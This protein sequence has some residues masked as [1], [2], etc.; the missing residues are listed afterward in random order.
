MC[1]REKDW[2]L[3]YVYLEPHTK[4]TNRKDEWK[5]KIVLKIKQKKTNWKSKKT[6]D[7]II[8]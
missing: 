2:C 5:E 4:H 1:D 8:F 7:K 3:F 6:F